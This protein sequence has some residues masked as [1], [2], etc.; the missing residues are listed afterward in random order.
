MRFPAKTAHPGI[1]LR[2]DRNPDAVITPV[3][4]PCPRLEGSAL[5]AEAAGWILGR[6]DAG[7]GGFVIAE[8]EPRQVGAGPG[9]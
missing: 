3:R 9:S 2:L 1:F 5:N 6:R 7:E 4:L 8:I